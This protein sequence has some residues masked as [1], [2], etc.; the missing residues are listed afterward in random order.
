VARSSDQRAAISTIFKRGTEAYM[1]LSDALFRSRYDAQLASTATEPPQ[2]LHIGM[3]RPPQA[4]SMGPP[5]LEDATRSA[6]ARPFARRAE[7]LMAAGDYRQAK[8]QLVMANHMDPG[9]DAL[10]EA[11]RDVESKLKGGR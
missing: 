4:H 6:T 3:S 5:K 10:E 8:L 2:R 9:N 7:E 1:V 11:M